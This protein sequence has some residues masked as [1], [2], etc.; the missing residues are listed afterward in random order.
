MK[1]V[2]YIEI[3]NFFLHLWYRLASWRYGYDYAAVEAHFAQ[4]EAA[5]RERGDAS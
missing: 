1:H 5:M 2:Q 4:L 3:R